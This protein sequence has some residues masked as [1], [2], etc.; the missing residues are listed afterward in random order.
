M[1]ESVP[2]TYKSYFG[3]YDDDEYYYYN[4]YDYDDYY[5]YYDYDYV[6]AGE[7]HKNPGPRTKLPR[8][9]N[10]SLP[11]E[12]GMIFPAIMVKRSPPKGQQDEGTNKKTFVA[13]TPCTKRLYPLCDGYLSSKDKK[14]C[15]EHKAKKNCTAP[16]AGS[17]NKKLAVLDEGPKRYLYRTLDYTGK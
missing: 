15:E 3:N 12:G 8:Q 10:G 2:T 13:S 5:E 14:D 4:Y 6:R 1:P 9:K 17:S 7:P 11:Q 16:E